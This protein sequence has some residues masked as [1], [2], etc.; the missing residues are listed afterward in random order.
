MKK[1]HLYIPPK[2]EVEEL[3]LENSI[4]NSSAI[5]GPGDQNND[6]YIEDWT[7]GGNIDSQEE[8]SRW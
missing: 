1:K 6:V 3:F 8:D 4:A 2:I 7:D 5:L